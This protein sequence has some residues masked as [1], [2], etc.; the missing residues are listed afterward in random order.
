MRVESVSI[1]IHDAYQDLTSHLFIQL[2]FWQEFLKNKF[3]SKGNLA[4]VEIFIPFRENLSLSIFIFHWY[5]GGSWSLRS[6]DG[7]SKNVFAELIR[8]FCNLT[9]S[10][11]LDFI[12]NGRTIDS[13]VKSEC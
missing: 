6:T 2:K 12:M 7:K 10:S 8:C 1:Y 13:G 11:E 5:T 9:S 3:S 4:R